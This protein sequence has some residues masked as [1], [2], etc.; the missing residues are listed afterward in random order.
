MNRRQDAAVGRAI[1][2]FDCAIAAAR[3]G[4]EARMIQHL[5]EARDRLFDA[6]KAIPPRTARQLAASHPIPDN[7]ATVTCPVC[8]APPHTPC[9][10]R[11]CEPLKNYHAARMLAVQR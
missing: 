3:I 11:S 10:T 5:D 9:E 1:A 4:H 8:L 6:I 2:R 7:A